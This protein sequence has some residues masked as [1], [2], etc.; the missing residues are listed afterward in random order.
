LNDKFYEITGHKIIGNYE[1]ISKSDIEHCP[2]L[3]EDVSQIVFKAQ[4]AI[5]K[6]KE[7]PEIP[8]KKKEKEKEKKEEKK[9]Q[10][11]T[12]EEEM[13]ELE[14]QKKDLE[15]KLSKRSLDPAKKA[16]LEKDL[17]ENK[18]QRE[19]VQARLESLQRELKNNDNNKNDKMNLAIGLGIFA[20]VVAVICLIIVLAR[21]PRHREY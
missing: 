2:Y 4:E 1:G 12:L 11:S 10:L 5:E 19:A 9:H 21:R 6:E 3:L 13:K 16:S 14:R 17:K 20:A 7:K 8:E 18:K 15:E